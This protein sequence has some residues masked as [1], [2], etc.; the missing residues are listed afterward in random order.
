MVGEEAVITDIKTGKSGAWPDVALQLSAYANAD[1]LIDA[2]GERRPLPQIDAAAV[3]TVRPDEYRLI[4]VRLGDDVFDTF[5][6]LIEVSKW[7]HDVSKTVIGK[8]PVD[9]INTE[10]DTK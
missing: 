3:L 6:A 10:T 1:Y 2:S 9:P 7:E 5:K 8:T 4:P